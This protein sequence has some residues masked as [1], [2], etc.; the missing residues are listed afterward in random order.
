MDLKMDIRMLFYASKL[1]VILI[2]VLDHS[3]HRFPH[4]HIKRLSPQ[5]FLHQ[6]FNNML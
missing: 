3:T 4:F 2:S 1:R 5:E 6:T